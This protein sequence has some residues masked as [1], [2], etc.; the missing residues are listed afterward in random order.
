MTTLDVDLAA[1]R[2]ALSAACG[3][4]ADAGPA[5]AV[6]GVTPALVARPGSTPEVA[7]VLRA[8]AAHR[9]AVVPRG[10]GTKLTWGRP[11]ERADLVVDLS[12]MDAV[13]DHAAGDLIVEA[14]AGTTLAEVQRTVA[15]AGQRLALD[16]TVP[17]GSVGGTL[18]TNASGPGRVA[19]GTARDLLIG[20]TVVRADGVVA[21]AGGRVVKNVA[22]YDLGKLVIGS[23]GTLA[24]VTEAVFR[25]HPLP[26]ARSVVSAPFER[27]EEAQRLVQAVLQAQVVPSAV[28][29]SWRPGGTGTVSVLLEGIEAGVEGRT[30]TTR[31]LLGEASSA[32]A[33]LPEDWAALPWA[34]RPGRPT[35]LKATF[36]LSG[37]AR[38]LETA[39]AV[40]ADTGLDLDLRG[41]AGAGVLHGALA[42]DADPAAVAR[43]VERLRA[44]CTDVGGALVVLD[45]APEV[46]AA[47]DTWGP[48]PALDLMRRVKERFDPERRLA[49]GRFVGGI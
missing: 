7:E 47:V 23:F 14:Q 43:V 33:G 30:A 4:V 5:D 6:D 41:S 24:V 28:E 12:R 39:R 46:A 18:A 21:K 49:P 17:G 8:A 35:A 29:V 22:G 42:A 27:P 44:E 20:V 10:R 31:Q 9:L 26:A 36:A 34:G 48:V 45:A 40:A 2:T 1:A 11:P 15:G 37:L 16:E 38:V 3:E 19:F 13:L 25:L 32:A